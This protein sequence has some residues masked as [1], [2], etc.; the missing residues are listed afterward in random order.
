LPIIAMTANAFG[1]DRQACLDAGM[2]DH[3]AKPVD[4]ERLYATLA[5]WL[6]S[7]ESEA[8]PRA[9]RTPAPSAL[10]LD[11]SRDGPAGVRAHAR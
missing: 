6:P 1:E 3:V 7:A 11:D 10:P 9:S 5:R 4:P 2:N 8:S